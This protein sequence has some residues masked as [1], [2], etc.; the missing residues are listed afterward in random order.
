VSLKYA[1]VRRL[2][3][4]AAALIVAA[5]RQWW[6]VLRNRQRRREARGLLAAAG[7]ELDAIAARSAEFREAAARLRRERQP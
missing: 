6:R 4:G 7:A 5:D 1:K 2:E 3:S